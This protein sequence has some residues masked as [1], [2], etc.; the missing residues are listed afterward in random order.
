MGLDDSVQIL[1]QVASGDED[2]P[3]EEVCQPAAEDVEAGVDLEPVGLPELNP[4]AD[5]RHRRLEVYFGCS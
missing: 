5:G 3:V 4:A 1:V 2:A